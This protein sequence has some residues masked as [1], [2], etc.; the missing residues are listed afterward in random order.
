M[1]SVPG[2]KVAELSNANMASLKEKADANTRDCLTEKTL[3][4]NSLSQEEYFTSY[5]DVEVGTC[6]V[7]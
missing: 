2:W 7:Y 4:K 6:S 5:E 3:Q 1:F